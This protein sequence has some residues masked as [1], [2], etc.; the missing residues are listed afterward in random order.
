MSKGSVLNQ[1]LKINGKDI[2]DESDDEI[3]QHIRDS[4]FP[5]AITFALPV[6]ENLITPLDPKYRFPN[7]D[8]DDEIEIEESGR[9]YRRQLLD[10]FVHTRKSKNSFYLPL[11]LT[12]LLYV[13]HLLFLTLCYYDILSILDILHK[14]FP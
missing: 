5:I 9:E 3:Q 14:V 1:V 7:V 2:F 10:Y 13:L 6:Q 4:Q 8:F 11:I 12:N